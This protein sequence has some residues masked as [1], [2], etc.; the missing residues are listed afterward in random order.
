ML[1]FLLRAFLLIALLAVA[2]S[3]VES[4]GLLEE[5]RV[6]LIVGALIVIQPGRIRV[7]RSN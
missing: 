4:G 1:Q 2:M 6:V 7:H 5:F 3:Y